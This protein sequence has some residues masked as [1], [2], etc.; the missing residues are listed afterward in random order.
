MCRIS[1]VCSKGTVRR[2]QKGEKA[3]I[4]KK[5]SSYKTQ[6]RKLNA[7]EEYT[8]DKNPNPHI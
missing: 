5:H 6:S 1:S 7:D 3:F 2:L 8:R 4:K